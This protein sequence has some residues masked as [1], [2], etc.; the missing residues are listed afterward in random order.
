MFLLDTLLMLSPLAVYAYIRIRRQIASRLLKWVFTVASVFLLL[1][2]PA[3]ETLSHS[4]GSGW[5]RVLIIVG[6]CCL[7]ALMYLVLIVILSDLF[8]GG[9]RLLRFLSKE[10]ASQPKFRLLRLWC[11]AAT[12]AAVVLYG[13]A[14]YY[15]IQTREY[16]IEIPRRSSE[17]GRL[18][19]AFASDFHLGAVTAGGFMERFVAEVNAL[20]PDLVLIGGDIL[21]G[22]REDEDT[23]TYEAQF[24]R[25]KSKYGVWAVPG[26]HDRRMEDRNA[27]F[28]R[29]GITLLEDRVEQI[30]WAFCLAGRSD[31]RSAARKPLDE[32]LRDAPDDLPLI[33]MDHRPTELDRLDR[34]KVDL[35]LSGHTHHGQV[36][37]ANFVTQYQYGLSYGYLKKARTHVI[38]TS[39]VQLWGP[40]IRTVGASEIVVVDI[41]FGGR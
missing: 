7:P 36:F 20:N 15:R 35:Q 6:Y 29:A 30:D 14:N 39:G 17:I 38:V 5:A 41:S 19:I 25:L 34:S 21:E 3:A 31:R 2:Y 27:F 37:P 26:N 40:P 12:T 1:G 11:W 33:L 24:R 23:A 32:L 28:A 4:S 9:L 8:T 13:A 18:R 22:D 16:S 10:R